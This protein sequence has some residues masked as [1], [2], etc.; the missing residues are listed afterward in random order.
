M[1]AAV[2]GSAWNQPAVQP[3]FSRHLVND[4]SIYNVS[5]HAFDLDGDGDNDVAATG[6]Q[7]VMWYRNEGLMVR[8]R[9]PGRRV[10]S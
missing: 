1:A 9:A 10:L 5:V 6:G 2:V 7:E 3:V 8:V 4:N